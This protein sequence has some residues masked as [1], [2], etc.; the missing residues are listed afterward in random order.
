MKSNNQKISPT[1]VLCTALGLLAIST[2][3]TA[4]VRVTN[5]WSTFFQLEKPTGKIDEPALSGF[6]YLISSSPDPFRANDQY[7][8]AGEETIPSRSLVNDLGNAA[9][10]S[11]MPLNFSIQHNLVGG[12]NFT[13]IIDDLLAGSP[14]VLCW[15]G[16]CAPG[17]I[18]AATIDGIAPITQYNG[19]QLQLRSQEVAGS[20]A[21]LSNLSLTGVEIIPGSDPLLNGTVTP[22]TPSTILIDPPGRVGQWLLGDNLDFVTQEWELSGTITLTRSDAIVDLTKV[23]L[24]VD[25][26]NDMRLPL[27]P[28]PLPAAVWLFASAIAGLTALKRRR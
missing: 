12:R 15:G 13:F 11:G 5:D 23:R 24:A 3:A 4:A 9:D 20:S 27:A 7:L 18:S 10:L 22:T 6:E 1:L 28:V 2:S 21:T 19:L 16:N 25:F 14:S 17:S 8:I 26:V